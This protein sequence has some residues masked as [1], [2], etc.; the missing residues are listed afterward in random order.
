MRIVLQSES[1][2]QTRACA[3]ALAR[4]V[5]ATRSAGKPVVIALVGDLG[6][7][8]TEFV[9]GFLRAC[10][11]RVRAASP[12]FVVMKRYRLRNK[13]H[14]NLYHFDLYRLHAGKTLARDLALCGWDHALSDEAIVL[15]EWA[16]RAGRLIPKDRIAVRIAHSRKEKERRIVITR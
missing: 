6:A 10:G 7:G 1:P 4:E 13:Q 9:K 15:V 12:S 11:I 3:A 5:L 2:A 16:D 14:P 8:K